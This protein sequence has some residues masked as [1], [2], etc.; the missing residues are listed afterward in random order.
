LL[1]TIRVITATNQKWTLMPKIFI[2]PEN[3]N[4]VTKTK[5]MAKPVMEK[6]NP[7]RFSFGSKN[8]PS[9][10]HSQRLMNV[11]F[12]LRVK[13]ILRFSA[14]KKRN[15]SLVSSSTM[16]FLLQNFWHGLSKNFGGTFKTSFRLLSIHVGKTQMDPTA[17]QKKRLEICFGISIFSEIFI[18]GHNGSDDYIHKHKCDFSKKIFEPWRRGAV[19]VAFAR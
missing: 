3:G 13:L 7:V 18:K 9:F 19:V 12:Y 4:T 14:E 2:L 15:D 10:F 16:F 5:T 11:V 17:S 6:E 8:D 1:P